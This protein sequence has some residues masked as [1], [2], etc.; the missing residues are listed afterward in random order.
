MFGR[1]TCLQ[2]RRSYFGVQQPLLN[3]YA[4]VFSSLQSIQHPRSCVSVT[5]RTNN[6]LIIVPQRYI[7]KEFAQAFR[8]NLK[9]NIEQDPEF[10]GDLKKLQQTSESVKEVAKNTT[11]TSN[12]Y[13]K[14]IL[15]KLNEVKE[16]TAEQA[17]KAAEQ[18]KQK[19]RSVTDPLVSDTKKKLKDVADSANQYEEVHQTKKVIEKTTKAF[20]G[21]KETTSKAIKET[22]EKT[23][24]VFDPVNKTVSHTMKKVDKSETVQSV[25]SVVDVISGEGDK[26]TFNP[27]PHKMKSTTRK[28]YN[29]SVAVS[30]ESVWSKL[31]TKASNQWNELGDSNSR[32]SYIVEAV[33]SFISTWKR[34]SSSQMGIMV[35][36]LKKDYPDFDVDVFQDWVTKVLVPGVLTSKEYNEFVETHSGDL[37][38]NLYKEKKLPLPWKLVNVTSADIFPQDQE[39][40]SYRFLFSIRGQV[41]E[42]DEKTGEEL[43]YNITLIVSTRLNEEK[44]WVLSEYQ[45]VDKT[46]ALF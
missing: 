42:V 30:H 4:R 3:N 14:Q 45:E 34:I 22:K 25:R 13:T 2:F 44:V 5:N 37:I 46:E 19:L 24:K 15:G 26:K 38:R 6:Q 29:T 11:T 23:A 9:K 35:A 36:N 16:K 7:L 12:R 33:D 8:K 17:K 1:N 27:T 32:A 10:G 28:N 21:A 31:K 40:S 43:I 18:S 39:P 20:S 41:Q